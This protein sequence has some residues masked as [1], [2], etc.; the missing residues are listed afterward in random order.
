M[1]YHAKLD[2]GA[3]SRYYW[4]WKKEKIITKLIIPFVNGQVIVIKQDDCNRIL[5][6]RNVSMLTIYKTKN[7]IKRTEAGKR[8]VEF[9]D[10]NFEIENQ[11]TKELLDE[12]RGFLGKRE[13]QSLLQKSFISPKPQVFVIMKFGDD[14]LDSAYEGVIK[15]IVKEFGLNPIRIDEVQDSGKITDQVLQ[16]IAESKYI[17]ADLT[18]ERPNCYYECGFA[19][20]LG[21]ELILTIKATDEIHFDLAVYR[22]IKWKTEAN[23]KKLLRERFESLEH[24]DEEND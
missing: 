17:I 12:V 10:K 16:C 15:P 1:R 6:M 20:A 9:D 4:N 3:K 2:Y 7:K 23:L 22:F 8:P 19:H 11:C 24:P 18:G 5:N 13:I 14:N 21:K